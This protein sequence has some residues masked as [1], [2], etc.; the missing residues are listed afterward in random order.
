QSTPSRMYCYGQQHSGGLADYGVLASYRQQQFT[1][2]RPP[3]S[4]MPHHSIRSVEQSRRQDSYS[5]ESR[6]KSRSRSRFRSPSRSDGR[7]RY[8]SRSSRRSRRNPAYRGRSAQ[9]ESAARH[10]RRSSS[11]PSSSTQSG[12]SARQSLAT[13]RDRSR[14]ERSSSRYRRRQRSRHQSYSRQRR[15]RKRSPH[16][17][18]AKSRAS[19]SRSRSRGGSSR[20]I[21][22]GYSSRTESVV[23]RSHYRS[24]RRYYQP[25]LQQH[26]SRHDSPASSSR[27]SR[28]RSRSFVQQ[29]RDGHLVVQPGASMRS[30]QYTLVR[31]LGEGTFGRVLEAADRRAG[32][33]RVAIKVVRNV[34]KYRDAAM[35]EVKVLQT[36]E[37]RD[38]HGRFHC[39]QLRQHFNYH[40]HVCL[41]FD[42]L[43]E[44]V[45]DF[46]KR[47]D[48]AP[49]PFEQVRSMAYQLSYAVKF[50]HDCGLTHTDLK[51]ENIL[52]C[53][54]NDCVR[55][56]CPK[57][58]RVRTVLRDPTIRLIDFGSATFDHEHHTKIVSTRHYRAPEVVLELGWSHPCDVWSIACIVFELYTGEC[59]FMTHDN[60]EHLAMMERCFGR[61]PTRMI[62]ASPKT[63][64]FHRGRLAWKWGGAETAVQPL[65]RYT[66]LPDSREHRLLFDLLEDLFEYEPRRRAPLGEAI[67][68]PFFEALPQHLRSHRY[69]SSSPYKR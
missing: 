8:R 68:H 23:T 56:V 57:T 34:P 51:P 14:R 46:Q 67:H 25:P 24:R 17:R 58:G 59:L 15:Q 42:M 61:L 1:P 7:S 41:V 66:Q 48:Y 18:R 27:R 36:L 40:G 2:P 28:S 4:S 43:G 50:L 65:R 63:K 52:F 38:P 26:Q 39:V 37:R 5:D 30:G 32:N 21:Q 19:R 62:E 44:S 9:R 20:R 10:R 13:S 12:C 54:S 49:Y 45:F 55:D 47:N 33:E 11:S 64:Y 53:N 6:S 29:D 35:L 69:H 60:L 16:R 31:L 3:P 22:D